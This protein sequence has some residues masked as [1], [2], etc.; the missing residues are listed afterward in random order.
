MFEDWTE[1][2]V[3]AARRIEFSASLPPLLSNMAARGNQTITKAAELLQQASTMLLSVNE[4]LSETG[5]SSTATSGNSP[6]TSAATIV[7]ETRNTLER[8]KSMMATSSNAGLYKRLNKYERLRAAAGKSSSKGSTSSK[9]VKTARSLEKKPFEFALLRAPDVDSDGEEEDNLRNDHVINRGIVTL[10]ASDT[11]KVIREKIVSSLK[12][13]YPMIESRDF[14]FVKVVQK[15]ISV[16]Q[17]GKGTEYDYTVVK[18][19]AGQG[20]LYIRMKQVIQFAVDESLQVEEDIA[21]DPCGTLELP[22]PFNSPTTSIDLTSTQNGCNVIPDG[23]SVR[24]TPLENDQPTLSAQP[25]QNV[26]PA[27]PE[28]ELSPFFTQVFDEMPASANDPTE[29]L[30]FLQGKI[31]SGRDLDVSDESSELSGD[32]NYI[33]VD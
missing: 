2:S 20:L 26:G 33:S 6:G 27:D 28:I 12:T 17:M 21:E 1:C 11:E 25:V 10:A 24:R 5:S 31:L 16:L 9:K 23:T 29:M 19:L 22:N 30:R 15:K 32:T 7:P 13:R 3:N 8:A 18:K 4:N 14:E